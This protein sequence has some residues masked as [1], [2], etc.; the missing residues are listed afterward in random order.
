MAPAGVP[1]LRTPALPAFHTYFRAGVTALQG[2]AKR[3]GERLHS[4]PPTRHLRPVS[5]FSISPIAIDR[6]GHGCFGVIR[7]SCDPF[8]CIK[9][10]PQWHAIVHDHGV[11]RKLPQ[12]N[13]TASSFI[14]E[15]LND[16]QNVR[17]AFDAMRGRR[18]PCEEAQ[19]ELLHAFLGCLWEMKRGLPNRWLQLLAG[20]SAGYST[21][22]LLPEY[23]R[24]TRKSTI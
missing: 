15:L 22:E 3:G 4:G 13:Q 6:F 5:V 14:R 10:R 16:N 19:A 21:E 2:P 8:G 1:A 12:V 18:I 7:R 17:S 11:K 9:S 20:L 23:V 24:H